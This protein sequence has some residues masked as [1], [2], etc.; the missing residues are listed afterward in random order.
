MDVAAQKNGTANRRQKIEKEEKSELSPAP[1][2]LQRVVI[3]SLRD[4]ERSDR[5][6][7]ER[8]CSGCRNRREP[9]EQQIAEQRQER[10]AGAVPKQ[11]QTDHQK[12]EVVPVDDGEQPDQ[13]DL[14]R[15]RRSRQERYGEKA[16]SIE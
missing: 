10:S 2:D 13:K 11:S 6:Q 3:D 5:G 9:P 4:Q 8:R 15:Q 12:C 16:T 14:V 7:A 1:D